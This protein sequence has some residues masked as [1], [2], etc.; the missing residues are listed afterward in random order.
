[1]PEGDS[2]TFLKDTLKK[3]LNKKS[4]NNVRVVSGKYSSK[5]KINGTIGIDDLEFPLKITN[6]NNKGK[7]LYITTKQ[8]DNVNVYFGFTFGLTGDLFV[9]KNSEEMDKF[10]RISFDLG[11]GRSFTRLDFVD[12]RNFGNFYI[13][14]DD[15]L[16]VKLSEIGPDIVNGE[17]NEHEFVSVIRGIR[18]QSEMI[19]LVLVNQSI[20]AGIGNWLRAEILYD[21]KINPFAKVRDLSDDDLKLIYKSA[22]KISQKSLSAFRRGKIISFKVYQQTKDPEGNVVKNKKI[23]GRTMW[24]VPSIQIRDYVNSSD[25]ED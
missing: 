7:F 5:K 23:K 3:Q 20:I 17:L 4:I 2:I 25:E 9:S 1:M 14:N 10:T 16:N 15:E 22:I 18:N 24:Y 8:R 12:M 19:C 21:A 6:V 13:M 11:P